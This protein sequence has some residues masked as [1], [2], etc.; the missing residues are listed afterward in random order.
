[1]QVNNLSSVGSAHECTSPV[2]PT[3]GAMVAQDLSSLPTPNVTCNTAP[4]PSRLPKP[5]TLKRTTFKQPAFPSAEAQPKHSLSVEPCHWTPVPSQIEHHTNRRDLES[6]HNTESF[7]SAR[8]TSVCSVLSRPPSI[9]LQALSLQDSMDQPCSPPQDQAH[10]S[11]PQFDNEDFDLLSEL[12][13]HKMPNEEELAFLDELSVRAHQL[14]QAGKLGAC[15][16]A[17][18]TPLQVQ[19]TAEPA[20]PMG[21]GELRG[22]QSGHSSP[23]P[24]WPTT[25]E[26]GRPRADALGPLELLAVLEGHPVENSSDGWVSDP[27]FMSPH[28][29]ASPSSGRRGSLFGNLSNASVSSDEAPHT[30]EIAVGSITVACRLSKV[31]GAASEGA[32]H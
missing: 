2:T 17:G 15:V 29:S 26:Q 18:A 21:T 32:A 10:G 30:P 7:A 20:W 22:A 14:L 12:G 8:S 23:G 13:L 1:V 27:Q 3:A 4:P 28:M 31:A 24:E 9:S 5:P 16:P 11:P 6:L 19:G 25:A